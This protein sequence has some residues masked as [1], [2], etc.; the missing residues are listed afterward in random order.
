MIL[1]GGFQ[2]QA[3]LMVVSGLSDFFLGCCGWSC[4]I[5]GLDATFADPL[6]VINDEASATADPISLLLPVPGSIGVAK[7]ASVS[8]VLR[9][10]DVVPR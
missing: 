1:C 10:R 7:V 9:C 5:L 2:V 8:P 6:P 3:V 4:V